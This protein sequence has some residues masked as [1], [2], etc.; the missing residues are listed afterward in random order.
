MKVAVSGAT[1]FVG[2]HLTAKLCREGIEVRVLVRDLTRLDSLSGL[3]VEPVRIDL[4]DRAA[5][6][7]AL[8]GC[9]VFF[10]AAAMVAGK[11]KALV[12]EVN[13][14]GPRRAVEAAAEAGVGRVVVT[15][16]ATTIGPAIGTDTADETT[17]PRSLGFVYVDSKR[18]GER[19]ALAAGARL[20][21]EVVVVNPTYSLGAALNRCTVGATSTRVVGNYLRGRLPLVIDSLN[22]FVD[23]EDVAMG[24]LLAARRGVAGSRYIL[25][26]ED[27]G[28]VELIERVGAAAETNSPLIVLPAR[29]A[30][31]AGR[32]RI[33]GFPNPLPHEA[34]RLMAENWCYSSQKS[35]AELGYSPRPINASL[36]RTVDWYRELIEKGRFDRAPKGVVDHTSA[37]LRIADRFGVLGVLGWASNGQPPIRDLGERCK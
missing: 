20:G 15:S 4:F 11:P 14:M 7:D 9:D 12:W 37:A 34:L 26:G 35:I 33:L 2:A 25:G 8:R 29:I 21:I 31:L 19:Q 27:L 24:H 6:R 32:E 30:R 1:G 16:T 23:V 36:Q 22:N 17:P 10:H 5:L 13:A 28:W 18:E 3:E